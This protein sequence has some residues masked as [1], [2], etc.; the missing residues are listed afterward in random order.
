MLRTLPESNKPNWKDS[1]NH[2]VH[3]YNCTKQDSTGFS[4]YFL[5]FG[6]NP[7]LPIDFLLDD[8]S[9]E[10]QH[11]SYQ[12]QISDWKASMRE[13]HRIAA[14]NSKLSK[15]NGK[16]R[17]NTTKYVALEVGDRVLVKNVKEK[18]G[19]GKIRA[20]WEADIYK[21]IGI[22]DDAGVVYE[23]VPE[24]DPK[25]KSRV[26]HRNMLLPCDH[27]PLEI[28]TQKER[29]DATT[30]KPL[31][32]NHS[33]ESEDS[34]QEDDGLS[35]STASKLGQIAREIVRMQEHSTPRLTNTEEPTHMEREGS[36]T[37]EFELNETYI[38]AGSSTDEDTEPSSEEDS[39]SDTEHLA[40]ANRNSGRPIRQRFPRK[41][42]TY[43]SKGNYTYETLS[44]AYHNGAG[45]V[46]RSSGVAAEEAAVGEFATE[47]PLVGEPAEADN[48]LG[49]GQ[50]REEGQ[51]LAAIR[52]TSKSS[53]TE[54]NRQPRTVFTYD[55]TGNPTDST[56]RLS[57]KSGTWV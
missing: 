56:M 40:T 49:L 55:R 25:A 26:L 29:G 23:V 50:P 7:R 35:A 52:E 57:V 27:L 14:Q 3:A 47:E 4:P 43:D 51:T 53:H 34:D 5:L 12:Q 54:R 32:L 30:P 19:P 16:K 10:E 48:A 1:L 24:R 22:K 21:I 39:Q 42:F 46:S 31:H 45:D 11:K 2:L 6:R 38:S 8:E 20:F 9:T 41:I 17:R 36:V 33:E 44:D 13:A 28:P 18:G 15:D 37:E